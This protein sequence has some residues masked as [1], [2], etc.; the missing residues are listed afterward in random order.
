MG[1]GRDPEKFKRHV[2]EAR[3]FFEQAKDGPPAGMEDLFGRPFLPPAGPPLRADYPTPH[4]ATSRGDEQ[5]DVYLRL[6]Q[7]GQLYESGVITQQEFE[8]LKARVISG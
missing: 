3:G 8:D 1:W 6:M 7:L 5:N 4:P 2:A